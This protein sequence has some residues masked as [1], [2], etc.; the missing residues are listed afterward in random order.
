MNELMELKNEIAE[1][2][3]R[4]AYLKTQDGKLRMEAEMLNIFGALNAYGYKLPDADERYMATIWLS[5][6]SEYIALYGIAQIKRAV[7][8]FAENDQR[9]YKSCPTVGDIRKEIDKTCTNPK[10]LYARKKSEE[11]INKIIEEQRKEL[12]ST[13]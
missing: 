8:T 5:S 6:L 1:I 13:K 9:E 7:M 12:R 3:K 4:E 10:V 2:S 11:E